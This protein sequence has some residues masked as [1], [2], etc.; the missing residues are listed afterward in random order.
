MIKLLYSLLFAFGFN[1]FM[2]AQD[3]DK[4]CPILLE[5]G[6]PAGGVSFVLTGSDCN[7]FRNKPPENE[8][9]IQI[10]DADQPWPPRWFSASVLDTSLGLPY[11][12]L[13][14]LNAEY[15][16]QNF[17]FFSIIKMKDKANFESNKNGYIIC[18]TNLEI[19][20]TFVQPDY[21]LDHHDFRIEANGEKLFFGLHDTVIDMS[22]IHNN[23]DDSAL[24]LFYERIEITDTAGHISFSW[25]PM[26]HL[27]AD[28]PFK[29]YWHLKGFWN[30]P[31]IF[32]WSHGNSVCFDYDGDILYSFKFIGI[33]KISR[34]D[35]HIIWKVDRKERQ[36]NS[37]SDPIPLFLQH[38]LKCAK[39]E[40]G[41][42]FYTFLSNG[43]GGNK[44]CSACQ[45]TV[46]DTLNELKIFRIKKRFWPIDD[47]PNSGGGG[48]YDVE[49]NG[50]YLINYGN[51]K[52]DT[53][54]PRILFDCRD[55]N[56]QLISR[57]TI[58]VN[59]IAYRVHKLSNWRPARPEVKLNKGSLSVN[60][61]IETTWYILDTEKHQATVVGSGK[62]FSPAKPGTYCAAVK[63]GIGYA[64]SIPVSYPQ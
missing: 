17:S 63:Y 30:R 59:S 57:Y 31:D 24:K 47:I 22:K 25:D 42:Q 51:F 5:Q 27:G 53:A 44:F 26:I 16:N 11:S 6:K 3:L 64:V 10:I 32:D 39:D 13:I 38:D 19:R 18:D 61:T 7:F 1:I 50:N 41:N 60:S 28:A 40:S 21:D 48:N 23:P 20:N 9:S 36:P 52:T 8:N 14:P 46:K 37:F 35:G 15:Q 4:I 55:K 12:A 58:P 33:G 29:K 2:S 43:D 56:D 49:P 45:F 62:S 34:K 54:K